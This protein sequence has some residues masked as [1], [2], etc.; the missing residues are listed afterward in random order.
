MGGLTAN[1][2]RLI[3]AVVVTVII[4][5]IAAP[6]ALRYPGARLLIDWIVN[7]MLLPLIIYYGIIIAGDYLTGRGHDAEAL[8]RLVAPAVFIYLLISYT[9]GLIH[10]SKASGAGLVLYLFILSGLIRRARN[11]WGT[12]VRAFMSRLSDSLVIY[13]VGGLLGLAYAPMAAPFMYAAIAGVIISIAILMGLR[14]SILG[15]AMDLNGLYPMM[16]TIILLMGVAA[17]LSS[18]PPLLAYSQYIDLAAI[19][20]VLIAMILISHRLYLTYSRASEKMAETVYEQFSREARLVSTAEDEAIA[21]AIIG[22]VER[23][24]KEELIAYAAHALTLCGLS[25]NEV[26]TALRELM[27]YRQRRTEPIWPWEA[28]RAKRE[29]E[30]DAIT[31]INIAKELITQLSE[32]SKSTKPK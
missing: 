7:A 2:F 13:G 26:M 1:A 24:R 18:L 31:R 9:A 11:G 30:S 19:V 21:N 3:A 5:L 29:A 25:I 8:R 6:M 15:V 10:S 32:C 16:V 4:Y 14:E 20:A 12:A 23:G 22:F 28:K 17:T 27:D